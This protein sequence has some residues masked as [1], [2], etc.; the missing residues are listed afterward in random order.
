VFGDLN[1]PKSEI[2]QAMQQHTV[3][4]KEYLGTRPKLCSV[5]NKRGG[6]Q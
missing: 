4:S 1:N 2:R 5:P 3:K 6:G